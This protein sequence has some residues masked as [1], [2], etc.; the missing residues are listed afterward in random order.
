MSSPND[1]LLDRPD[2]FSVAYTPQEFERAIRDLAPGRTDPELLRHRLASAAEQS[3]DKKFA[4]V[5]ATLTRT[6]DA[7][8]SKKNALNILI[9]CPQDLGEGDQELLTRLKELSVHQ[10]YYLPSQAID[11]EDDLNAPSNYDLTW[12]D[13]VVVH[14]DLVQ[15]DEIPSH[16]ELGH[17]I[18]SYDGP[19]IVLALDEAALNA[20]SNVLRHLRIE[21][22]LSELHDAGALVRSIEDFVDADVFKPARTEMIEVPIPSEQNLEAPIASQALIEPEEGPSP[23]K[24]SGIFIH[25]H[26]PAL[27][28]APREESRKTPRSSV[29]LDSEENVTVR[30]VWSSFQVTSRGQWLRGLLMRA[31]IRALLSVWVRLPKA[32]RDKIVRLLPPSARQ[33][34]RVRGAWPALY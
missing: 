22:S 25:L 11:F 18:R 17:A 7:L 33:W 3:Y 15:K 34:L 20:R 19:K 24:R 9:I 27:T 5:A 14:S 28:V 26:D 21:S 13:A 6:R 8:R 32:V 1:A 10:I 31:S 2:I 12:F 30:M 23:E 4:E 29:S 16:S